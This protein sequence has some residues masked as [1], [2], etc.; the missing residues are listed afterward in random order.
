MSQPGRRFVTGEIGGDTKNANDCIDCNDSSGEHVS[1]LVVQNS[2]RFSGVF[3]FVS[4]DCSQG[5]C[6]IRVTMRH[7]SRHNVFL[8]DVASDSVR[9]GET[10]MKSK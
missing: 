10:V 5:L 3:S 9:D 7:N 6:P 4:R 1:P 8:L 2:P